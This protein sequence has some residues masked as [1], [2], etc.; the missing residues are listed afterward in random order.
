[1]SSRR[2][3]R[4]PRNRKAL[5]GVLRDYELRL[6]EDFVESLEVEGIDAG[7]VI[8]KWD[9]LSTLITI[10]ERLCGRGEHA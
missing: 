10:R 2:S 4:A 9:G 7:S 3:G 8:R 1:M 5:C 6:F